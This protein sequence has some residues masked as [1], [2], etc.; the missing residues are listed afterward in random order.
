MSEKEKQ[1]SE[2]EAAA[3][4]N[5]ENG[6]PQKAEE[7][8]EQKLHRFRTSNVYRW[9]RYK[10]GKE[11]I[12]RYTRAN[13]DMLYEKAYDELALQQSKRDQLIG[14]YVT[15]ISLLVSSVMSGDLHMLIKGTIFVLA[16]VIGFMLS[17][18]IIRYRIYK[19]VYWLS[20]Q[21]LTVMMNIDPAM[22]DEDRIKSIF[23]Q[24]MRTKVKSY[25][26]AP[27][28][29]HEK[30]EEEKRF[31][32]DNRF[33]A[34]TIYFLVQALCASVLMVLGVVMILLAVVPAQWL[35]LAK[36]HFQWGLPVAG[37]VLLLVIFVIVKI[38]LK[39]YFDELTAIY[40]GIHDMALFKKAFKKA[41]FLHMFV[42]PLEE[43]KEAA[44]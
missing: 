17:S 2:L 35:E 44:K 38:L 36:G 39:R 24:V 14:L 13:L 28:T 29:I 30:F 16:A 19:E 3:Q 20:C 27:G 12:P 5:Q 23:V 33:S 11:D 8:D 41:W 1:M 22:L 7:T 42:S 26:S 32:K 43:I 25:T 9:E 10:N 4:E 18:V 31:R 40:R 34:E 21:T 15:V 37:V 6:D